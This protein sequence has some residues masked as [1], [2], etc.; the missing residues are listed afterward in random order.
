MDINVN[1]TGGMDKPRKEIKIQ[2][3]Q[4]QPSN[5]SVDGFT[6]TTQG[7]FVP[8]LADF[9][10][11]PQ[12]QDEPHQG[13][14]SAERE[15]LER[16]VDLERQGKL[17]SNF[18]GEKKASRLSELRAIAQALKTGL[19]EEEAREYGRIYVCI[20]RGGIKEKDKKKFYGLKSIESSLTAGLTGDEARE[21]A[22][23]SQDKDLEFFPKEDERAKNRIKELS[24]I[25][26][27]L[28]HG[29]NPDDAR[30][31]ARLCKSVGQLNP[32]ELSKWRQLRLRIKS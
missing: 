1:P 25:K 10:P 2:A 21:L 9:S 8:G 15:E 19:T 30:D 20:S 18:L 7:P 14:K 27:A 16:L 22:R 13:L 32:D 28:R 6:I 29:F 12:I 24:T 31:Y 3:P 23:L 5:I 11:K 26:E 4:S 17:N